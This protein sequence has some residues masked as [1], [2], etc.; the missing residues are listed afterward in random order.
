MHE[1]DL[2]PINIFNFMKNMIKKILNLK[3]KKPKMNNLITLK[4]YPRPHHVYFQ[5]FYEKLHRLVIF[6]LFPESFKTIRG[7]SKIY[8]F[9]FYRDN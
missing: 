8:Y 4:V 1:I 9:L 6:F 3:P 5:C 2:Y 7:K